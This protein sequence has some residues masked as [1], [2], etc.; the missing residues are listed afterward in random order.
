MV[1][2]KTAAKKSKAH[3]GFKAE[4]KK[5]ERKQ[6]LSEESAGAILASKA[7]EASPAANKKNPRL[8]KVKG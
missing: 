4:E 5:I 1:A 8:N 7:R 6:G 3:P 2:K